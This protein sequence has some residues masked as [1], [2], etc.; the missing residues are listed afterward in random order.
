MRMSRFEAG[1]EWVLKHEGEELTQDPVWT[2]W[3]VTLPEMEREG[4]DLDGDGDVDIEDV[5][6]LTQCEARAFYKRRF[7]RQIYEQIADQR[8]ATKL[9]DYAI[10][11][12]TWQ[13]VVILQRACR[14]VTSYALKEDGVLGAKTLAAVNGSDPG[15]LLAALCSEGG[16]VY[17]QMAAK[18]PERYYAY[19]EGW[20]NRAYDTPRLEM[21]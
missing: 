1:I 21:E 5:K 18:R 7:W 16:G 13:A 14:A 3:G 19:L 9:L 6:R 20:L 12:G 17:R 4:L 15:R 2:R 10:N 8:V 11:M